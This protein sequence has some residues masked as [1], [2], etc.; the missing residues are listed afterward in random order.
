[1]KKKNFLFAALT[2]AALSAGLV[3][4]DDA[5]N[6]K[7]QQKFNV[8]VVSLDDAMGTVTGSGTYPAG[9]EIVI[10]ATANE[11]YSFQKWH[12]GNTDNPRTIAVTADATYTAI[13]AAS[14]D[15]GQYFYVTVV[16]NNE[17]LGTVKGEGNY[18][19][20]A[21]INIMATPNTGSYFQQW[22]DGS[23][24][25]VRTIT[26]TADATYTAIFAANPNG[27]ESGHEWVDLGLSVKWATC[28]VGATTPEADGNYYAWGEIETKET[29]DWGTYKWATAFY[30]SYQ[31]KWRLSTLTKYNTNS[32]YGTVDNKTVLE[33]VDDAARANWGGAWR[34]PTDA[35][36]TELRENCTWTWTTRNGV[37]GCEVTS[38][39]NGNAIFLP[40]ASARFDDNYSLAGNYG[41]YWSSSL[42]T[43]Y[44]SNAW[45]VDFYSDY[46][47]RGV[48]SRFYGLSV[49]PVL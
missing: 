44:P 21:K 10:T 29:Y 30:D 47:G 25:T 28:N 38:K 45:N 34:M 27:N 3:S 4:C 26:V 32:S 22:D 42:Y 1:M 46:V 7:D 6:L 41:G 12:D 14:Y 11:G 9:S 31:S 13:F 8:T 33:L 18:P 40:A 43:D 37:N 2:V 24:D 48:G 35:E 16:A 23:T 36:W 49:R 39:I 17:V 5:Q 15:P 20:G 19:A